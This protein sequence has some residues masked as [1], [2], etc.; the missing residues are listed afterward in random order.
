M[1]LL[2]S[3]V[4]H[5]PAISSSPTVFV[6]QAQ[7]ERNPS[8]FLSSFWQSY[9]VGNP[10]IKRSPSVEKRKDKTE[11]VTET[12][13]ITES[14][15]STVFINQTITSHIQTTIWSTREVT[16]TQPITITHNLTATAPV[17]PSP[18]V[19]MSTTKAGFHV[20]TRA[21]VSET[22]APSAT[23]VPTKHHLSTGAIVGIVFGVLALLGLLI[24]GLFLVRRFYRMYR[25]ERVLRKQLQT[26]GNEMPPMKTGENA[27]VGT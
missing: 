1:K 19:S 21:E 4:W 17:T 16:F 22:A 18:P 15:F 25:R 9:V 6:P 8:T 20:P 12:Q 13:K 11:T 14:I 5:G 26:E 7:S 27:G 23:P 24:A 10:P 2:P 3:S